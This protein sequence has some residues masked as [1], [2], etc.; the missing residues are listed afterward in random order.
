MVSRKSIDEIFQLYKA[1]Y[2]NVEYDRIKKEIDDIWC[3]FEG[4]NGINRPDN[5]TELIYTYN[6]PQFDIF[7]RLLEH[8]PKKDNFHIGFYNI[9]NFNAEASYIDDNKI[10]LID[11]YLTSFYM[12]VVLGLYFLTYESEQSKDQ[13][14]NCEYF[15]NYCFYKFHYRSSY[16]KNPYLNFENHFSHLAKLNYQFVFESVVSQNTI[17][18]FILGHELGHFYFNHSIIKKEITKKSPYLIR[19]NEFTA[20]EFGYS[21]MLSVSKEIRENDNTNISKHFDRMPI[22][23]FDIMEKYYK[24][25]KI[26]IQKHNHPQPF[27]RK[28]NLLSKLGSHLSVEGEK[29][30]FDL[31]ETLNEVEIYL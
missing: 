12:E 4:K 22:L 30:Y 7:K 17:L 18:Y 15:L 28:N 24:A 14:L 26:D 19:S 29:L 3:Y 20:D 8:Y 25:F 13:I 2:F 6:N 16:S 9:Q 31:F 23:M 21:L 5:L 1:L 11:N 27:E 10:I